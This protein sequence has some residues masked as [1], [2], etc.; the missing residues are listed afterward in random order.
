MRRSPAPSY[1]GQPSDLVRWPARGP[2]AV[3]SPRASWDALGARVERRMRGTRGKRETGVRGA[4]RMPK[5]TSARR[6]RRRVGETRCGGARRPR[7]A[8]SP[9]TSYGGQLAG[10]MRWPALEPRGTRWVRGLSAGCGAR[11]GS[12]RQA[13][14]APDECRR[15][16]PPGGL[17]RRRVG[18]TWY[19]GARRPRVAASSRASWVTARRGK[20]RSLPY[21][22]G[23]ESKT[24]RGGVPGPFWVVIRRGRVGPRSGP[25]PG[26]S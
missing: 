15:R 25:P 1:G 2:H 16:R 22:R 5:A 19:G 13:S 20:A 6:P 3:A 12:V 9:Q 23:A 24:G 4:R 11:A 21:G 7:T 26:A 8:A 10:L 14:E 18:E 17:P